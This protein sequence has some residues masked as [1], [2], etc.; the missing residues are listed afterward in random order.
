[1]KPLKDRLGVSSHMY[2]GIAPN[3][4]RDFEISQYTSSGLRRIRQ[5]FLWEQIEPRRGE[6]HFEAVQGQVDAARAAGLQ[7]TALLAYGTSW[8]TGGTG[9]PDAI[10]PEDF[11]NFA[12][13]VAQQ[14]CTSIK[15]YEIWNEPDLA[16]SWPPAPNPTHYGRLLKVAFSAIKRT[17][18]DAQVILGGLS[19][20]SRPSDRWWFLRSLGTAHPD[21]CAFFD[22]LGLHPYTFDQRVPPELNA[23]IWGVG[24]QSQVSMT[25][26]ARARLREMGC[27]D[28]PLW[29][30]ELG[31]PS[32]NAGLSFRVTP[33]MQARFLIRSLLLGLKE[34]V[35]NLSI[36]TFWDEDPSSPVG[37]PQESHFGLFGWPRSERRAKPAFT[38]VQNLLAVLGNA[39][40]ITDASSEYVFPGD[41][42]ALRISGDPSG[43]TAIAF[44][45]GRSTAITG[46]LGVNFSSY[47][48]RLRVPAGTRRAEW[49]T[50]QGRRE[51]FPIDAE[52]EVLLVGDVS[53]LLL[54]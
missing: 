44:W 47:R 5:D 38:A 29:F 28:K 21:I 14:Y 19:S 23:E 49:M 2:Q 10:A 6:F 4:D 46:V 15:S 8:A 54:E 36:Y 1:M 27:P 20:Y 32:Y 40:T 16:G 13:R 11:A 34:D 52:R 35:A 3:A 41:V 18:P 45:D 9:N 30:T 37:R 31:W 7:L 42:Y 39:T 51:P 50:M 43:R 26:V 25:Q 22:G 17:C 12:G 33:A 24:A 53:Y 48:F